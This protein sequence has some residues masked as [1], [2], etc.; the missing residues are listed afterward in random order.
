VAQIA[1]M[2]LHFD[3]LFDEIDEREAEEYISSIVKSYSDL[4][5]NQ[6]SKLRVQIR[7]GSVKVY[8]ALTGAIYLAIGQYG[9]FRSGIDYMIEDAKYLKG[10]VVSQLIKNGLSESDVVS[11][12]KE[13]CAPDKIRRVLLSIER[14]E[15]K[16]NLSKEYLQKELSKIKSSVTNIC[17]QLDEQ[18]IGLFASSIDSKYLPDDSKIPEIAKQYKIYAREEDIKFFPFASHD[19]K[20]QV[21]KALSTALKI[22]SK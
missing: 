6:E 17:H 2:Y 7:E 21:N 18:D 4:I 13:H 9:S 14:L 11:V 20:E 5:F 3:I 12:R 1:G 22:V 8:V 16:R 19:Y 15:S 10:L